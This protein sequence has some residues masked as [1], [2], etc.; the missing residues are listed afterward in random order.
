MK[1]DERLN[2]QSSQPEP[3]SSTGPASADSVLR[4]GG[5]MGA[6][7]R[8]VD[9][10]KTPVGP[11]EGWPQ[12]LKTA[13][14]IL[15]ESTFGTMVAWGPELTHFYNDA[16][17]PILGTSKHPSLG[18]RVPDVFPEIWQ[19]IGPLFDGVMQGKAVGFDDLLVPL[20]RHGYLEE[21]YFTFAY[22]PIRD[23]AGQVG[24]VLVTVS[25]TTMRLIQERRLRTLRDL[26]LRIARASEEKEAW[27]GGAET[28]SVND[29]D[30]PFALLY[31]L[32]GDSQQVTLAASTADAPLAVA[33]PRIPLDGAR[34]NDWP[35][36]PVLTSGEALLIDDVQARFGAPPGRK[37]PEPVQRALML[38]IRRAGATAAYG[39]LVMGISPRR[40]LDDGYRDFC[41]LVA[42][43][44]AAA[45][46][47]SRALAEERKRAQALAEIDR[48]KTVF[49]SNVSHEFRTP[50]TLMLGP[51]RQA[52]DS[53][54]G[55]LGGENLQAVHRNALRLLKLVNA[56]LDFARAEAGRAQGNYRSTDLARLT[57]DVASAFHSAMER[58]GLSFQV[59]CPSLP[60]PVVV[61]H[62][63]WEKIVLNLLS[64]AFK[65]TLAGTIRLQLRAVGEEI[66]LTVSDT[67]VGIPDSDLPHV[68]ER[69][70][71]VAGVQGRTLEGSGIGL[72]LVHELVQLHRGRVTVESRLGQGTTFTV[73]LPASGI[74]AT[75]VDTRD[76]VPGR[77]NP[78]LSEAFV[79]EALGW[80]ANPTMVGGP[81]TEH[82]QMASPAA[83]A[84]PPPAHVLLADDSADMRAYITRLLAH[85]WTV[86]A[87]ADGAQALA[88]VRQ[89][90]PDLVL[91]DVM[92]PNIDG[93]GLLQALRVDQETADIPVIMLSARAGEES[94]VEGL[95][96]G[97]DDYLPKPFSAKELV[98][99]VTTHLELG[100]LRR[101]AHLE[102]Q[103]LEALAESE[104][105]ARAQAEHASRAKDEFL[106]V[107]GHELR[108]PLAPML[109]AL[110]LLQIKGVRAP[111]LAVMERQVGAL[112]RL[113]DDLMDVSRITR[114]KI[115]LRKIRLE[116]SSIILRGL[117]TAS[118]LLEQRRHRIDLQVPAQGLLVEGDPDRLSQ[119]FSNLLTNAAKYSDPGSE[120]HVV[121][122]QV[123]DHVRLR[124]RDHGIGIPAEMLSQ[125]FDM[126]VQE[127]QAL[128]RAKG[129]VGL[130]LT[131]VRNLVELH[132]GKVW[133]SS[134]GSGTGS[135]FVVE[136][137]LV[138]QSRAADPALTRRQETDAVAP[139]R[140]SSCRILVVDD[141]ED[142][143][144]LLAEFLS[145]LGYEVR[146]AHDGPSAIDLAA[147]F[148]PT[149]CLVDIGL[150]V[151]D[152]YE[153]A[154]RL[155]HLVGLPSD[156]HLMAV[157]GY[158]QEADRLRS[159]E[160]GF[161]GHLVK[162][163][164]LETLAKSLNNVVA[165]IR[166]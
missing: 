148:K 46:A 116:L 58:G 133:A 166:A 106:A 108:N 56:L 137:P 65:F 67:G 73:S 62:D 35:I 161:D 47:N 86:Q 152:G 147:V 105:H 125:V 59:D 64:N 38:P 69:F 150:P 27:L 2:Q 15:L 91:T 26:A 140:S 33:A 7:M 60:S 29:A 39:V 141:N 43:Q 145:E 115:E 70:R 54:Q 101:Q 89:R 109:T 151:M 63:M 3:G 146:T 107:L 99:R 49:F 130:G 41:V 114:G 122:E 142:A 50:L 93:F 160:A 132:S 1:I 18:K 111:E 112:I 154:K 82:D 117:E 87:V 165:K 103:K 97:A 75:V 34:G 30:V 138:S 123:D 42:D 68:F 61:D 100:R 121:A 13:L 119:V 74:A 77:S 110:R 163:V 90:R 53:P 5:Q 128:D 78:V 28:L 36:G 16:Y 17:R 48:A 20:D 22:T 157:T 88:A 113:V 44:I 153:V 11:V 159:R 23:E 120:I 94:R 127:P 76:D 10:S 81:S 143:A 118:P 155:R 162:P 9:W 37:W 84:K 66:R 92:M 149:I 102:R 45:V 136:L 8:A 14:S 139:T 129:G 72:A 21:C 6:L 104:R 96:A 144:E 71:T 83:A 25:E 57:K 131:I 12:S 24:G 51:L 95:Q 98:A 158:G 80:L 40:E 85:R 124:I 135:E 55:T 156:V 52:L 19:T 79:V 164:D 126:F 31:A 134:A 4:G 32:D